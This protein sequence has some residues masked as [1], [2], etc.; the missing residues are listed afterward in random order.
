ME[1]L[2][3]AQLE[4]RLNDERT[5]RLAPPIDDFVLFV[6]GAHAAGKDTILRR[7][8]DLKREE[9]GDVL[10]YGAYQKLEYWTDRVLREG[11][12]IL[13]EP[14]AIH[15]NP[16]AFIVEGLKFL[17]WYRSSN[18]SFY[19][20]P[21]DLFPRGRD[22]IIA[23][24]HVATDIGLR[25]WQRNQTLPHNLTAFI[26]VPE[27]KDRRARVR[28]RF[29]SGQN[30]DETL[31]EESFNEMSR[32]NTVFVNDPT[33]YDVMYNNSNP[34]D[35]GI[36]K[37]LYGDPQESVQKD[38]ALRLNALCH[39]HRDASMR[40]EV[41]DSVNDTLVA[42]LCD[43]YVRKIALDL[44]SCNLDALA[45]D[46]R[47]DGQVQRAV[48]AYADKSSL[49]Y[50]KLSLLL[51]DVAI[52]S[53]DLHPKGSGKAG[54]VVVS[55][56]PQHHIPTSVTG[57]LTRTPESKDYHVLRILGQRIYGETKTRP[58]YMVNSNGNLV[59]FSCSLT[60][61]PPK[62]QQSGQYHRLEIR[63]GYN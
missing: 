59:G 38:I 61:M 54:T 52:Q 60:D 21:S 41:D 5:D 37:A 34:G 53:I 23:M 17:A 2:T 27:K 6:V 22:P 43:Q 11:E 42:S 55:L 16:D 19:A 12:E 35:K 18:G 26:N 40:R 45:R 56:R 1:M 13:R 57:I 50:N 47:L 48:S 31:A 32:I 9:G 46:V 33:L 24:V 3:S 15:K 30:I 51:K 7:M 25:V 14:G 28:S 36:R 29:P 10:E 4:A 8:Q 20:F 62:N 39:L 58:D 49:D 63:L 44:F